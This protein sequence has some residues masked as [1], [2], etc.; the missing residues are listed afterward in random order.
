MKQPQVFETDMVLRQMQYAGLF[1]AIAIRKS[2]FPDRIDCSIFVQRYSICLPNQDLIEMR[3]Q[4]DDKAKAILILDVLKDDLDQASLQ[5]GLTKVF[6]R[7]SQRQ[8]LGQCR[9]RALT[10]HALKLQRFYRQAMAMKYLRL[11]KGLH[12][13]ATVLIGERCE[14]KMAAFLD[15]QSVEMFIFKIMGKMM[16]FIQKESQLT[17]DL[18]EAAENEDLAVLEGALSGCKALDDTYCLELDKHGHKDSYKSALEAAKSKRSNMMEKAE[19]LKEL[20]EAILQEELKELEDALA[21]CRRMA[22]PEAELAEAST[23]LENLLKEVAVMNELGEAAKGKDPDVLR[24][25]IEAAKGV[26]LDEERNMKIKEAMQ[27]YA[28]IFD[29]EIKEAVKGGN[30]LDMKTTLI[31]RL[32]EYGVSELI[33]HVDKQIIEGFGAK[34]EEEASEDVINEN[35]ETAKSLGIEELIKKA[36]GALHHHWDKT[37]QKAVDA[38]DE[39]KVRTEVIPKLTGYGLANLVTV[40][41]G[42]IKQFWTEQFFNLKMAADEAAISG[43]LIPKLK[44]VGMDALAQ[45]AQQF[46]DE[47]AAERKR[48]EELAAAAAAAGDAERAA[49]EA[50]EA[51]RLEAEAKKKAEEEAAHD[52]EQ[53]AL[54]H[55]EEKRRKEAEQK[56]SAAKQEEQEERAKHEADKKAA[57]EQADNEVCV[58]EYRI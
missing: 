21:K 45:E 23:L 17:K 43:E 35:I 19:A 26:D 20:S 7:S 37:L 18:Q 5:I 32:T 28:G 38:K 55:A 54:K 2:G 10:I 11:R 15:A 46:L 13:E 12:A 41:D 6:M 3:K 40:A 29:D 56:E 24:K 57:A 44:T 52:A 25:A 4:P 27:V 16:E 8:K 49:M 34:L 42:F 48:K 53:T 22:I 14:V 47:Q 33:A 50:A 31:P 39:E 9:D 58:I 36:Q 30:F 51:K 1:E